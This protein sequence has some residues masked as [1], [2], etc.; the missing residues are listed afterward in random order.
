[1][2]T[3]W[4]ELFQSVNAESTPPSSYPVMETVTEL[5]DFLRE[6]VENG[7]DS[8]IITYNGDFKDISAR[9]IAR[10]MAAYYVTV[11]KLSGREKDVQIEITP[12]PGERIVNAYRS[13]DTS[14]LSEDELSALNEAIQVAEDAK[15]QADTP[16]EIEL[17][18]HDWLCDRVTY[19]DGDFSIENATHIVRPLTALGAILDGQAN[20]QGYT[21]A[22]Y[23]LAS[24]AGFD[25]GRQS[26][27]APDGGHMFNTIRMGGKWYIVD[28]TFNDD[29]YL[30]QD[31]AYIDYRLFN[32][33]IDVCGE[34]T[35]PEEYQHVPLVE[36]SDEY[37][38][39]NLTDDYSNAHGYKKA[40]DDLVSMA[41]GIAELYRAGKGDFVY[42]MLK[43]EAN[44]SQLKSALIAEGIDSRVSIWALK[45]GEN[46][47]FYFRFE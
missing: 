46:T 9:N 29:T 35:W 30:D 18:L 21:D 17:Y 38:Y 5:R 33:G 28:V 23:L 24:V 22:F 27:N 16:V 42:M 3:A 12:Y 47:F 19:Y 6:S 15:A 8:T 1:M 39:Y 34:Y 40:Y 45:V 14:Q 11:R 20:C 10:I 36:E 4:S 13:G 7:E 25:V 41:K 37:Y 2:N 26:C 44:S 31:C 43:G 32:A